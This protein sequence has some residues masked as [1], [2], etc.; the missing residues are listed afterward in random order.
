MPRKYVSTERFLKPDPRTGSR[1]VAKFINTLMYDGKKNVA[2]QVVYE[3]F[4]TITK[5][6]PGENPEEVFTN[7][8][9]NVKPMV[10]VRSKRV[11]G[12]NYQVPIEVKKNR[13]QALAFRWILEACR[14]RGGRPMSQRLAEEIMA[15]SRKEGTAVT[16]R[17]NTHKMADANKMNAHFAW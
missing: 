8:I 13:Q 2:R 14:V 3:C 6:M 7:A 15:A 12:A 16:K 1:L 4:D 10:E 11:G 9:M 17:E 5:K